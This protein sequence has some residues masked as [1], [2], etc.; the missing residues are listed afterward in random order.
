MRLHRVRLRNYRGVTDCAVA[1]SV[2]GV[3]VVEGPN[4]VGKTSIPEALDLIL[5]VMDSSSARRVKSVGP[6]GRD[7]GPDVEV[8]MSLGDYRFVYRKR[9]LRDRSTSLDVTSPQRE[10]LTGRE[11]HQ[12]VTEILDETLDKDLWAALRIGQG[13][14]LAL[15]GFGATTLG[16]AL[17]QAAGSA[18]ASDR[19]D[20]LWDRICEQHARYWTATGRP[21]GDR[22]SSEA[23][24][25]EAE[26]QVEEIQDRLQ[27]VEDDAAEV[28]RLSQDESRLAETREDCK[29]QEDE[30]AERWA[31]AEKLGDDVDR[32]EADYKAKAAT[33]DRVATDQQRRQELVTSVDDLT[34]EL[35]GLEAEAQRV[36]PALTAARQLAEDTEAA[37][38]DSRDALRIAES[39][40]RRANEDRD[41][42]R[43]QID[44]SLLQERQGRVTEAEAALQEAETHLETARVDD[45][46]LAKIEQAHLDRV[47]ADAAV[48]SI[49]TTALRDVSVR[50]DGE[51]IALAA[52][53]T[54]RTVVE[55]EVQ[56]VVADLARVR[57]TAGTGN[58][59]LAVERSNAHDELARLCETGG[60]A[61]LA[62]AR[63]A[64]EHRREAE[65]NRDDARET[66][67]RELRDLTVEDLNSKIRGL[68]RGISEHAAERPADP[69]MPADFEESKQ[70][71]AEAER[72]VDQS[73]AEVEA[74]ESADRSASEQWSEARLAD[75]TL[76]A[77]IESAR[78]KRRLAESQLDTARQELADADIT[79]R[80]AAAQQKAD[81]ALK[82]LEEAR[83]KLE[84]ADADSLEAELQNARN[85]A[86][87]AA[88]DL[89][90]N[91]ER[92]NELRIRLEFHGEQGLHTRLDEAVS[93]FEQLAH[94]HER[95][96][97]RAE[98]ARLLH[99]TFEQRR[100]EARRRYVE[101]FKQRIEQ[102]GRIVFNPTLEV[103]LDDD[104]RIVRRTLDGDSLHVDQLSTGAREQLGV[105]S[106]LACAAI[107]SPDGGG[108]PVIIDDA[109]GWSDPDRLRGMGAAIAA[110]SGQC[111]VIILTCTPDR[112]ARVGN[113]TT[114]RL[115]S[116]LG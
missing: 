58:K 102:L 63:I 53:E 99:A 12:R 44:V 6:V 9:W 95:T 15:P 23:S 92:Q 74:C 94:E 34:T 77:R 3:T 103:E 108:A 31:A 113:A 89:Q 13:T 57:V 41:H 60:V 29:R 73:K 4:E 2:E 88:D 112:Y 20:N 85:A 27:E 61:D 83:A 52:D 43:R 51:D 111:Q 84:E 104:L 66:I 25:N 69:P 100:R 82:T 32:L 71:A 5:E 107:V 90:S 93:Q 55:D 18:L 49:E 21:K 17:D 105:L 64:A 11:A 80:L 37:L 81:A 97:A 62:G 39:E 10:Q 48:A 101:P 30:T 86:Q 1:F 106:R 79:G 54:R 33:R 114:V 68:S 116:E 109:L 70:I 67:E 72:V 35:S 36:A 96:E 56:L 50:I 46:L 14:E 78:D 91:K 65:R 40:Q 42:H 38:K 7:S 19:E 98:A 24:V 47:A 59:S 110:A 87:R 16:R 8:E 45:D 28:G 22:T 115:P 75:A 26:K 76:S